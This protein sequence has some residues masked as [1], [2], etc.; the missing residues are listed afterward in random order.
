MLNYERV[1]EFK[2]MLVKNKI[3][4]PSNNKSN[5]N[6]NNKQVSEHHQAMMDDLHSVLEV[7]GLAFQFLILLVED[8]IVVFDTLF[9]C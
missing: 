2:T 8:D 6:N 4:P 3:L 9:V 1:Q 7:T 5:N